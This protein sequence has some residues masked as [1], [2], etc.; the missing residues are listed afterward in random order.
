VLT[1]K[2]GPKY[3]CSNLAN[4]SLKVLHLLVDR[5]WSNSGS[6]PPTWIWLTSHFCKTGCRID[7]WIKIVNND[8][9]SVSI[10]MTGP[11][12]KSVA[13]YKAIAYAIAPLRP[14]N[15]ITNY[16]LKLNWVF[17]DLYLFTIHV[18]IKMFMALAILTFKNEVSKKL[19]PIS[20]NGCFIENMPIPKNRNTVVSAE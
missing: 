9:I 3:Y 20:L 17:T 10:S 4:V 15:H 14:E 11:Y 2:K 12:F 13:L 6:S 16:F 8:R 5:G 18:T 1:L 19:Q 7:P